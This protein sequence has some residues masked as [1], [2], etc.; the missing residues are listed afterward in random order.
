VAFEIK[1]LVGGTGETVSEGWRAVIGSIPFED[2]SFKGLYDTPRSDFERDLTRWCV[3]ILDSPG[4]ITGEAPNVDTFGYLGVLLTTLSTFEHADHH[5]FDDIADAARPEANNHADRATVIG[6]L[7]RNE[8]VQAALKELY[9]PAVTG[10]DES[11][12]ISGSGAA[13]V[14][15]AREA[16]AA[17]DFWRDLDLTGL[18]FHRF[19]TT[20]FIGRVSN[21]ALKFVLLPY[22]ELP[23]ISEATEHYRRENRMAEETS[24]AVTV[25]YSST[26][27][28]A[29]EFIAGDTLE[30]Y[31]RKVFPNRA[32]TTT[33]TAGSGHT[34]KAL[35]SLVP[36]LFEALADLRSQKLVHR[37]LNPSNIIVTE[38]GPD[39]STSEAR[40]KMT[41]I[42]FGRNYLYG[43]SGLGRQASDANYI[44]PE[45]RRDEASSWRADVYSLGQLI[46]GISGIG[47]DTDAAVPD[48]FYVH[49]HYL[50]RFIEDLVDEDPDNRLIL[51]REFAWPKETHSDSPE[52]EPDPA[53]DFLRLR[54]VFLAELTAVQAADGSDGLFGPPTRMRRLFLDFAP[55]SGAPRRLARLRRA[56]RSNELLNGMSVRRR[57]VTSLLWWSRV[58][59]VAWYIALFLTIY[60]LLHDV[61]VLHDDP[62]ERY[63]ALLRSAD[64]HTPPA[65]LEDNLPARI[66]FLGMAWAAVKYYE[67][68]YAGLTA[69]IA[70]GLGG[71]LDRWR[72][73]AEF[74]VRLNAFFVLL[75][76]APVNLINPF[77][78]TTAFAFALCDS[79]L[80]NIA[81]RGFSLSVMK[82]VH[83]ERREGATRIQ[84]STVPRRIVGLEMYKV[85]APSMF[86]YVIMTVG[87]AL[88]INYKVL[89]DVIAYASV[90]A[91]VNIGLLAFTKCG[92]DA[93]TI[94]IGLT[95]AYLA[96]ERLAKLN[97]LAHGTR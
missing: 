4:L 54:D 40:Y 72:L 61:G 64:Y 22:A 12:R 75:V 8:C 96:A 3:R 46:V 81:G 29:M 7:F 33:E 31:I 41:M 20:S 83:R 35:R 34:A 39:P 92:T 95:R 13:N 67:N 21:L 16:I 58:S 68:I 76:A 82:A 77:W 56:I 57:Q 93:N 36:P 94:R 42:D 19:G 50:A 37:D 87:F 91:V 79:L 49:T 55:V 65:K 26:R 69:T 51:Y 89:S 73:F 71:K 53:P 25:C 38:V 84:L 52:P 97:R 30:E 17:A 59:A 86:A 18:L 9:R 43:Q 28:I 63:F 62:L 90:V 10:E 1:T 32:T 14:D 24:H 11:A 70:R 6:R 78:W 27:W 60:L 48:T 74:M 15:D 80:V 23:V 44:A 66:A 85:W 88:L 47:R 45:V 2:S 5:R